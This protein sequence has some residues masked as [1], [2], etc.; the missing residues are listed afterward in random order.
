M[1]RFPHTNVPRSERQYQKPPPAELALAA[2]NGE[3]ID[4]L[5]RVERALHESALR[6]DGLITA[7][8]DTLDDVNAPEAD[9]LSLPAILARVHKLAHQ[10]DQAE[11]ENAVLRYVLRLAYAALED[12]D[13]PSS[14]VVEAQRAIEVLLSSTI[15]KGR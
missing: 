1:D 10:R 6:F 2:R 13:R 5:G 3:L 12:L 8:N 15:T 4:R 7:V 9:V 11:D 14:L